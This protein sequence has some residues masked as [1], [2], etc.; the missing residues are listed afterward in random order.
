MPDS[1]KVFPSECIWNAFFSLKKSSYECDV[2]HLEGMNCPNLGK[3][4]KNHS[5]SKLVW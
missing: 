1:V 2:L 4:K 3:N 5:E